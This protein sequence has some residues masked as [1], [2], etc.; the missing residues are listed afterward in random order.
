LTPVVRS[1]TLARRLA[2]AALC[3]LATHALVYR[4][5]WPADNL[6]GYF[7]WYEPGVA[8]LSLASLL[9]LL[10][11]LVVAT[12]GRRLG[13]P[14]PRVALAPPRPLVES[15]RTLGSASLAFL[16]VQESLE[17]SAAAGG[18]VFAAFT[19]SQWL[20]I[21]AGIAA[22]SSVLAVVSRLGETAVRHALAPPVAAWVVRDVGPAGWVVVTGSSARARPLAERFALR[23]PPPLPS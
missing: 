23:A 13:R 20:T 16:L 7:G 9:G 8:A 14:L 19:P 15:V 11:L 21:V 4:S 22:T 12:V 6:H 18:P 10:S 2:A 17:R 3:A 5:L 1:F